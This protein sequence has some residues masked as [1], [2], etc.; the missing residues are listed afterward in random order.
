MTK[1]IRLIDFLYGYS[2]VEL[3]KNSLKLLGK[4]FARLYECYQN[5]WNDMPILIVM[6]VSIENKISYSPAIELIKAAFFDNFIQENVNLVVKLKNFLIPEEF[7]QYMMCFEDVFDV[8]TDQNS[9]LGNR[10]KDEKEYNNLLKDIKISFENCHKAL[11]KVAMSMTPSLLNYNKFIKLD[12]HQIE[13]QSNHNDL[14]KLY[15]NV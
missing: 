10:I 3:I 7:P 15:Q 5:K 8:S 6:I 9:N 14:I 12:F 11:E 4:R 13:A 1:Y 2:K